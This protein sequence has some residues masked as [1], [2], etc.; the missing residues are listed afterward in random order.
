MSD[1]TRAQVE[2]EYLACSDLVIEYKLQIQSLKKELTHY[3][4]WQKLADQSDEINQLK[5]HIAAIQRT[6]HAQADDGGLWAFAHTAPE[7]YLQSALRHLHRVCEGDFSH[8]R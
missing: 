7:G 1:V 8:A 4:G 6:V 3:A 2:R 5:A